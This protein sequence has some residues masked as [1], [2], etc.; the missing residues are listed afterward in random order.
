MK[1]VSISDIVV[2]FRRQVGLSV[3]RLAQFGC[4]V[5][6]CARRRRETE[7]TLRPR[8]TEE[9]VEAALGPTITCS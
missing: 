6:F 5:V 9:G 2:A 1:K 3:V 8:E 7:G 4:A